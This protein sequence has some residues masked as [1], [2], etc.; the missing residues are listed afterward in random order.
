MIGENV[1]LGAAVTVGQGVTIGRNSVVGA[2]SV[3]LGDIPA[4]VVA[5][6]SPAK[7]IR[8]TSVEDDCR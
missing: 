6:G 5:I 4:H 3:V 7:V 2:G 8:T 1:W